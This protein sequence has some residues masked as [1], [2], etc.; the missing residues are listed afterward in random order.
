MKAQLKF[1]LLAAFL[2]FLAFYFSSFNRSLL[3]DEWYWVK[4]AQGIA[5]G[6]LP[7]YYQG[8]NNPAQIAVGHPPLYNYLLSLVF[9]FFEDA[10]N[11]QLLGLLAVV[12]VC[13]LM[14]LTCRHLFKE[15][16]KEA[17]FFSV[18]LYLL[19]P[20]TV[21]GATL[22]D[23]DAVTLP[24]LLL[25]F[26]YAYLKVKDSR[27]SSA[28]KSLAVGVFFALLLWS[29]FQ[30][31]LL[32]AFL[33]AFHVL[34]RKDLKSAGRDAASFALGWAL[35]LATWTAYT[36]L[37]GLPFSLSFEHN[38]SSGVFGFKASK[39]LV[40]LGVFRNLLYWVSP[41]LL[42]GFAVVLK[43]SLKG[44]WKRHEA[45]DWPPA[46][47]LFFGFASMLYFYLGIGTSGVPKYFLSITPLAL[48]AFSG[49]AA[50]SGL[51][52]LLARQKFAFSALGLLSFLFFTA[53]GDPLLS[54]VPLRAIASSQDALSGVVAHDAFYLTSYFF[55]LALCFFLVRRLTPTAGKGMLLVACLFIASLSYS[56]SL[57]LLQALAPYSKVY[58]YGETQLGST[59][60]F[61]QSQKFKALASPYDFAFLL[62]ER[63]GNNVEFYEEGILFARPGTAGSFEVP[64][65]VSHVVLRK[66]FFHVPKYDLRAKLAASG[67]ELAYEN[68][69]F[70][71]HARA[72]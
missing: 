13:A 71:V 67:F 60:D 61:M 69:D 65:E 19:S 63:T 66:G 7:V 34:A 15:K 1:V 50:R 53:L 44:I 23:P 6:G 42:L 68:K 11:A 28:Q 59:L 33:I 16:W 64:L 38:L 22:V 55:A 18:L 4:S 25:L 29:K 21:Q 40:G 48:L 32:L 45:V 8:E 62:E 2:L 47:L 49:L 5:Q 20:L 41:F 31:A 57:N 24:V 72:V 39:L 70:E 26:F 36:T 58:F 30:G 12:A 46:L 54:G 10:K 51:F 9:F 27:L 35:F 43:D 14:A 3:I 56:V 52:E 37:T 17:A